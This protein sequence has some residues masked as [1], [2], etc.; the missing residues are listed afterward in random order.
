MGYTRIL[1][2]G[3]IT[4]IYEYEKPINKRK[5]PSALQA[6]RLSKNVPTHEK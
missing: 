5:Q 3:D 4:E 1:Q 6:L 2:Y